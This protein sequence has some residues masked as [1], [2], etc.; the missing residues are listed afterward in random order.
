MKPSSSNSVGPMRLAPTIAATASA[1]QVTSPTRWPQ[2]NQAPDARP[3][4]A[5]SVNS[6]RNAG[7]GVTT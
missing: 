6:A 2:M 5:A 3:R 1:P 4:E 7:P